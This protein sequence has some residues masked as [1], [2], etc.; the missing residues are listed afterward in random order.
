VIEKL[1]NKETCLQPSKKNYLFWLSIGLLFF[2]FI[3]LIKGVLLPFVLGTLIAYFLDPAADKLEEWRFSRSL[4]TATITLLFFTIML[5]FLLLIIPTIA[6]QFSGLLADLP[7]YFNDI[8]NKYEQQVSGWLGNLPDSYMESLKNATS[9][10]SGF[11]IKFAGDMA[12]GLFQSGMAII[13]LL[14]LILITPVVAF[15]LLRDWDIIKLRFYALL[16]RKHEG[17]IRKQLALIDAT[18]AGFI[19]G[20][21]NVCLIL[22][23]FYAIGLSIFG[24]K[25]GT[26]IGIATG[27]LV[28]LPYVGQM[29]GMLVG[30][31]VAYFQFATLGE[32]LPIFLVFITGQALEASVITPKLVGKKVGLHPVWIIFG[33]LAGATLFGFVGVLIAVP[34]SAVI[35]VIIRFALSRYLSSHYYHNA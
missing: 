8:S 2:I 13:N 35:G 10:F 34:V 6:G 19:R 27:F 1:D 7:S 4:A 31:C 23:G 17:I 21:M 29:F 30:L 22:G 20:Q 16:P 14:S 25:F 32:I 3:Y 26:L 28:I 33:M 24:L 9:N 11:M 15:Y 12:G 18:L 5:L